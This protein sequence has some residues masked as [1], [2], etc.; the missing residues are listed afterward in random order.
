MKLR[1]IRLIVVEGM[2]EIPTCIKILR[3]LNINPQGVTAIPKG[4][5]IQFWKDI[6]RYNQAAAFTGPI[7][8]LADLENAPCPS[9]LISKNLI[10]PKHPN[11]VLRI[12]E[13]MLESWLLA[14]R[15]SLSG[16]MRVNEKLFPA[17]PDLDTHPKRTLVNLAR[18]SASRAIKDDLIPEQ[19]SKGIVGKG[20]TTRINRFIE[21]GWN[22]LRAQKRSPSL[23]RAMMA[24]HKAV[25]C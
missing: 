10:K 19:G 22:P 12:A 1:P 15:E 11:L 7:L 23:K 16:F 5:R 2:L 17:N 20:Y 18:R 14:D 8:A 6:E 9:K 4:G 13:R 21:S 3:A 24:I 25:S